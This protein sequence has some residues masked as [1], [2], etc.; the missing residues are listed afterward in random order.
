MR[1][2]AGSILFAL[3][4]TLATVGSALAHVHPVTPLGCN[5]N[6]NAATSGG[7]RINTTPAFAANGGPIS[8]VIPRVMTPGDQPGEAGGHSAL[9][10]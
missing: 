1:R 7:L 10:P 4:L 6:D 2:F 5:T 3:V 9:C 8:G